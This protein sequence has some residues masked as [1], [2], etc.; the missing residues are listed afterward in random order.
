M[1]VD[2]EL[3]R[4]VNIDFDEFVQFYT[5]FKKQSKIKSN[6]VAFLK[7]IELADLDKLIEVIEK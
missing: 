5:E 1:Q 2:K 7:L 3:T 4:L 6:T